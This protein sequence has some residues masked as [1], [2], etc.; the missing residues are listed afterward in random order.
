MTRKLTLFAGVMFLLIA[1]K[2][3]LGQ[4]GGASVEWDPQAYADPQDGI[5]ALMMA[6]PALGAVLGA[7]RVRLIRSARP[8]LE[9][10]RLN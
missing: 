8:V 3:A 6:S 5:F 10:I 7:I 4:D 9:P 2:C 1:L